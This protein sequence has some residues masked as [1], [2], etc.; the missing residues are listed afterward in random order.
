MPSARALAVLDEYDPP[1]AEKARFAAARQALERQLAD[2]VAHTQAM[3]AVIASQPPADR[4]KLEAIVRTAGLALPKARP[5]VQQPVAPV[6]DPLEGFRQTLFNALSLS[7]PGYCKLSAPRLTEVLGVD[8]VAKLWADASTNNRKIF[9]QRGEGGQDGKRVMKELS[10]ED[11]AYARLRD[12]LASLLPGKHGH[13]KHNRGDGVSPSPLLILASAAGCKSQAP[14]MDG[15]PVEIRNLHALA[16][17]AGEL[18][19]AS[20][21]VGITPGTHIWGYHKS[22]QIVAA[23]AAAYARN[24]TYVHLGGPCEPSRIDVF[25]GEILFFAQDFVHAGGSYSR[26]DVRLFCYLDPLPTRLGETIST[27]ASEGGTQ[28]DTLVEQP[29]FAPLRGV[30]PQAPSVEYVE[31]E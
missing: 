9:Q 17:G 27:R 29:M 1:L 11:I 19:A 26:P 25:P 23:C 30:F 10:L 5:P 18:P 12:V 31:I 2:A 20:V 13:G 6:A 4:P 22:H 16:K 21:I 8:V 24:S 28:L 3:L 15:K 7:G 14:H